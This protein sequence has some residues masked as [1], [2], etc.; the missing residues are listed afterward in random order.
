MRL[1]TSEKEGTRERDERAD[2]SEDEP[3]ERGGSP[4]NRIVVGAA[5]TPL[6]LTI[7]ASNL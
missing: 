1:L 7:G 4:Q 6:L 3:A 5:D 2:E